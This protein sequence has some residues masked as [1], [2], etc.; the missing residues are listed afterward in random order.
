MAGRG[1][2]AAAVGYGWLEM[3]MQ[4]G[5]SLALGH[6]IRVA[7]LTAFGGDP[8][9]GRVASTAVFLKLG[10]RFEAVQGRGCAGLRGQRART[11]NLAAAK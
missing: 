8:G 10:V 1:V 6:N 4:A 3:P 5:T 9:Q 11:E 7:G 2:S